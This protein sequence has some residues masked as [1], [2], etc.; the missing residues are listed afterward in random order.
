MNEGERGEGERRKGMKEER[1]KKGKTEVGEEV[2]REG[3]ERRE[4]GL[5]LME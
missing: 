2:R 3:K 1:G 4:A 5:S